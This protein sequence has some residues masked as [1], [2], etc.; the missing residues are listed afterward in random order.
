MTNKTE[1]RLPWGNGGITIKGRN[2][3]VKHLTVHFD[4]EQLNI[5][6]FLN[7]SLMTEYAAMYEAIMSKYEARL[8]SGSIFDHDFPETKFTPQKIEPPHDKPAPTVADKEL[9]ETLLKGYYPY[10][11]QIKDH[12]KQYEAHVERWYN[13]LPES[14]KKTSNYLK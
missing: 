2:A 5:V 12:F 14:E 9:I 10:I 11:D 8:K 7:N 4:G 13:D 3:G 6:D 1:T